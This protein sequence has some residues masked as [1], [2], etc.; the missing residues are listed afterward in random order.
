MEEKQLPVKVGFWNK[1]K[2]I[3]FYEVNVELTPYQQR[4]P[5]ARL[6]K[7]GIVLVKSKGMPLQKWYSLNMDILFEILKDKTD[8]ITS[9]EETLHQDAEKLDNKIERNFTTGCEIFE[10]QDVK[11]LNTNNNNNNNIN[12][13]N[14]DD[15]ISEET[16]TVFITETQYND[17]I[18][19]Y[20]KSRIDRTI[21]RLDLY[22]KSTG[23][24]Y[25]DDYSTLLL[26]IDSDI[27]KEKRLPN[28]RL[29]IDSDNDWLKSAT[30][31]YGKNLEGLY[32]N[33]TT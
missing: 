25:E 9:S 17:L 6:E 29:N 23:K 30:E 11:K 14:E 1:L 27:E 28:K 16:K 31:K 20:G 22:K 4:L 13:N 26:W 32:A 12:N 33:F 21:T 8:L 5:L 3:L 2:S 19:K 24:R 15:N 7:M 10:Q 18:E